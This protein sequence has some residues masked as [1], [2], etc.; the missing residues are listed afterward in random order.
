MSEVFECQGECYK[1]FD[2]NEMC[3]FTPYCFSSKL[4]K[5]CFNCHLFLLNEQWQE[6]GFI[7]PELNCE[8]SDLYEFFKDKDEKFLKTGNKKFDC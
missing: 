4:I 7:Q 6:M 8:Y 1:T 2:I 3:I 5:C